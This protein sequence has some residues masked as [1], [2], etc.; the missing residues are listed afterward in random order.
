ML[1]TIDSIIK[2]SGKQ[3]CFNNEFKL[4]L[5]GVSINFKTHPKHLGIK[6]SRYYYAKMYVNRF[7]LLSVSDE[8]DNSKNNSFSTSNNSIHTFILP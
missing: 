3:T 7:Y 5:L 4:I 2:K 1:Q 8:Q 6:E